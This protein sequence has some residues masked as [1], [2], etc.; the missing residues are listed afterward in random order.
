MKNLFVFLLLL[1]SYFAT[2]QSSFTFPQTIVN[3]QTYNCDKSKYYIYVSNVNNQFDNVVSTATP[4]LFCREYIDSVEYRRTQIKEAFRQ[5]F[6]EYRV[7]EDFRNEGK[8]IISFRIDKN[9]NVLEVTI[10][11]SKELPI[12][13]QEIFLLEAKMKNLKFIELREEPKCKDVPNPINY[14]PIA[15]V[16]R[17]ESLYP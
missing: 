13:P 2:A 7:R 15:D 16:V 17:F 8:V 11:F 4:I 9:G 10:A 5:V 12:T 1:S 6:S 14:I 3:G